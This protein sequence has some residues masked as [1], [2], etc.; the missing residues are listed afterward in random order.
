[1]S[2]PWVP[3]ARMA[4]R[5]TSETG[6]RG[7]RRAFTLFEL[8]IV[9]AI[10]ALFTGVLVLRFE[11]GDTEESLNRAATDLKSAALKAKKRAYAFRRDQFIVFGRGGFVLT[12]RPPAEFGALRFATEADGRPFYNETFRLPGGVE[13]DLLPP[14]ATRWTGEPGYVW[15]FRSSGL[16]DPLR[17]RLS[18]G[19]SYARLDFNVLTALAEEEM[20][21]E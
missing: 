5:T 10:I 11:D 8:L 14:G 19:R 2:T 12:E 1:M 7:T 6:E 17:V 3:T 9:L 16:N 21:V 13:L 20:V 4:P 18:K 15:S